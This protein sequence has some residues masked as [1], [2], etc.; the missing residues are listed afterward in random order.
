MQICPHEEGPILK[1]ER[2]GEAF[3]VS[4]AKSF[5]YSFFV[6]Q[7]R[8]SNSSVA[9]KSNALP[10]TNDTIPPLISIYSI[11]ILS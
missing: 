1:A 8:E 5:Q 11:E 10:G 2:K 6:R 9:N 7:T 4:V 3:F